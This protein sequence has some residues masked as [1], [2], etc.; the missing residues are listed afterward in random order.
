MTARPEVFR[1]ALDRA[2]VHADAWLSSVP[3]RDVGPKATADELLNTIKLV[4]K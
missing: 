2:R 3:T 4:L 1:P